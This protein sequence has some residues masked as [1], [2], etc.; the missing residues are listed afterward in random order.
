MCATK[1]S[2]HLSKLFF[3]MMQSQLDK[4]AGVPRRTPGCPRRFTMLLSSPQVQ[5]AVYV[6]CLYVPPPRCTYPARI[7]RA[8]PHLMLHSCSHLIDMNHAASHSHIGLSIRQSCLWSSQTNS[9]SLEM[10]VG[11]TTILLWSSRPYGHHDH[12]PVVITDQHLV[13]CWWA[14]RPYPTHHR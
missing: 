5:G 6:S 13:S 12:I 3:A 14:S 9:K 2:E 1:T 8:I 10:L 7:H 4:I 11:I